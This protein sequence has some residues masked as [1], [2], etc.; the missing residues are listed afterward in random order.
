MGDSFQVYGISE[1]EQEKPRNG[2][3]IFCEAQQKGLQRV[4]PVISASSMTKILGL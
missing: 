2:D 3:Y 4:S 1:K